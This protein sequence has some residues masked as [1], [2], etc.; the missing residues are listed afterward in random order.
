MKEQ[1]ICAAIQL[2]NGEVWRGHR[3]HDCIHAAHMANVSKGDIAE[4]TQGF[5]TSLNRF[6][7]RREA[8]KIQKEAGIPSACPESEHYTELFS[9]DLYL[10][11]WRSI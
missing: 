10:R 7:D 9:E 5:I 2:K 3:H 11:E 8:K 4:G 1:C 6:V